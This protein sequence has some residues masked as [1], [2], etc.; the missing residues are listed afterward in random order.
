MFITECRLIAVTNIL[1][2]QWFNIVRLFLARV[3][4]RYRSERV[5]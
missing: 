1:I 5:C 4:V 2:F 3:G